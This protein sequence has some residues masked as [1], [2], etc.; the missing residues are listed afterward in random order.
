LFN[1]DFIFIGLLTFSLSA[2]LTRLMIWIGIHDN[3]THRSSHASKTPRSGGVAIVSTFLFCM[4]YFFWQDYFSHIPEWR[5]ILMLAAAIIIVL[6]SLKDDITGI[7][8]R[9]KLAIQVLGAVI[10][11][12]GGLSFDTLP[13]PYVGVWYLGGLGGVVSLFWIVG[14]MN[15]F[16]FMDGLDGLAAGTSIVSSI[17]SALIALMLGEKAI[18]FISFAL[19][20][21]SLGFFLF[22]FPPARI[23]MG[24]VGS[25]FLGFSWSIILI[26]AAQASHDSISVYTVPLLFFSFI[27]DVAVTLIRRISQQQTIWYPHR[28]FLF[29]ILNRSGYTHRQISLIYMGFAVLQGFGAILLQHITPS[30]QIYIFVPYIVLMVFYTRWVR[31]NAKKHIKRKT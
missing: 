22:N 2:A 12:T 15:A 26:L 24:D 19:I 28:T 27:Y 23:F 25:Q 21:S 29:H 14:F 13:L 8:F 17:F 9:K 18:F 20:W 5:L 6:V 10:V 16:N 4:I 31:K 1:T 11:V 3:P 7:S 30:R